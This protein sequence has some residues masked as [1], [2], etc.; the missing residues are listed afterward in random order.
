MAY[1]ALRA[2]PTRT[3]RLRRLMMQDLNARLRRLSKAI[4]NLIVVEDVFGI[5]NPFILMNAAAPGRWRARSTQEQAELFRQWLEDEMGVEFLNATSEDD[6]WLKYIDQAFKQG[7]NRSFDDVHRR[8]D[9]SNEENAALL[10]GARANFF[11]VGFGFPVT[12]AKVKLLAGRVL[13]ELKGITQAM[14]QK[15]MREL[16]DGF[17]RGDSPRKIAANIDKVVTSLG[18]ARANA[19]AR[20]EIVRA[21]VE[22]Q[23]DA[24]EALGVKEVNVMVEWSTAGDNKVCPLCAN[25]EGVVLTIDEARGLIPRH[26][27]CRCAF[28]PANVGESRRGQKRSYDAIK[29]AIAA[30]VKAEIPIGSKRT[31]AQQRKISSWRGARMKLQRQRPRSKVGS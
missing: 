12:L 18:R 15:I 16:V 25:M 9:G 22:G 10:A 29:R 2:D 1:N 17:I 24:M 21:F 27:N 14:A 20:T 28:M 13:T 3:S 4:Y 31:L 8:G 11:N 26:P 23:L 19:I 5:D 30:S 6:W 7:A